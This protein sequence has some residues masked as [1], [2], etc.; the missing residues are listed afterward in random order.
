MTKLAKIELKLAPLVKYHPQHLT[1]I[2]NS[3]IINI[4]SGISFL[5]KTVLCICTFSGR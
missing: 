1:S 5:A 3:A 4:Q 2:I